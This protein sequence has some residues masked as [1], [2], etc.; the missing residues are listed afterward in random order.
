MLEDDGSVDGVRA[1]D[2]RRTARLLRVVHRS[3]M[4]V[5]NHFKAFRFFFSQNGVK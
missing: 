3:T 2:G 1:A 4:T 5:I